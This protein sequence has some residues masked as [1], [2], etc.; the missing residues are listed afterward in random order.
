MRLLEGTE[1]SLNFALMSR[2]ANYVPCP[3]GGVEW[4][5]QKWDGWFK[6]AL[7]G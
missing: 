6:T 7:H 1:A 5:M 3:Y 2:M 4:D